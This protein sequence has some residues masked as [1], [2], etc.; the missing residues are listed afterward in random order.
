MKVIT[1]III[2][3]VL[4]FF[5][6]GVQAENPKQK[7]L[8]D[9]HMI[10]RFLDHGL[11]VALEGA[12]MQMLGQM[13]QSEKLDRDAAVHG[14]IMVKDGKAMIKEMLEGKAM[15]EL[16]QEGNFDK[17][18]MDDLH[19]LGE[20]MIEVIEQVEKIHDSAIKQASGK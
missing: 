9:M 6:S 14:T 11:C 17:K 5:A 10:M 16:Y 18:V 2:F 1:T 13:G 15:R 4:I 3:V 7:A 19:K 8:H 20:K 12:D